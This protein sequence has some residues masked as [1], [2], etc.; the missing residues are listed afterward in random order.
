MVN[1]PF[2][3]IENSWCFLEIYIKKNNCY[4]IDWNTILDGDD[5]LDEE[6][7]K[8]FTAMKNTNVLCIKDNTYYYYNTDTKIIS[9]FQSEYNII[10]VD[11]S[12]SFDTLSNLKN[13]YKEFSLLHL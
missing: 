9:P 11:G 12:R 2:Y 3:Y 1:I 7:C 8:E 13:K 10:S 4:W 5:S 6:R